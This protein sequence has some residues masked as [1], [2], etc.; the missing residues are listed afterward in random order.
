MAREVYLEFIDWRKEDLVWS[1]M[2]LIGLYARY[3]ASLGTRDWIRYGS[4]YIIPAIRGDVPNPVEL[5]AQAFALIFHPPFM[6]PSLTVKDEM[7]V[8][9][10]PSPQFIFHDQTLYNLLPKQRSILYGINNAIGE[11][12][13]E[14]Y[15]LE[16]LEDPFSF[17]FPREYYAGHIEIKRAIVLA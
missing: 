17:V 16:V 10:P 6:K 12:M 14:V 1:A 2:K 13:A 7:L 4:E 8:Y 5:D 3:F 11:E 9:K 15:K